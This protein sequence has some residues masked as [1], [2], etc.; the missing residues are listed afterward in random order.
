MDRLS[1]E[2]WVGVIVLPI[3]GFVLLWWANEQLTDIRTQFGSTFRF[4]PWWTVLGWI[5]TLIA[6]GAMFGLAV[7]LSGPDRKSP[8]MGAILVAA[9]VPVVIVVQFFGFLALGWS[10]L[11][12][13]VFG[14]FLI[15]PATATVSCV[16]LGFLAAALIAPR[17]VRSD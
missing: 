15:T 17:L 12:T 3:I 2:R 14:V 5:F 4:G 9:I 7:A 11:G 13:N 6:A 16:V 10:P 8:F 1:P